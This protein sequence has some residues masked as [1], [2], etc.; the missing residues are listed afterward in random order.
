MTLG[1]IFVVNHTTKIERGS[2]KGGLL[3]AR[4]GETAETALNP[5]EK[6]P[7]IL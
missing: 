2:W 1:V 7:N 4:A 6:C 3:A 5:E